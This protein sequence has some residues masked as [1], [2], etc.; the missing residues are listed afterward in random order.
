MIFM[1]RFFFFLLTAGL[2]LPIASCNFQRNTSKDAK[3]VVETLLSASESWNGDLYSYPEG[4]AQMTLL[5]ITA[6]VGFR[7]PVHTHPQPGVAYIVKGKLECVV[8]ADNTRVFAAGDSF[9]T[10]FG[11][12]PHYCESVGNESAIVIV[13]YAGVEEEPVTIPFKK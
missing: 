1:R 9:A 8:T 11:D 7:T 2:T 12:T 10:T 13:A 4:Q 5:K 3:P 6:P